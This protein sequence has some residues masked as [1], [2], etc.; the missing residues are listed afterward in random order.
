MEVRQLWNT[1]IVIALNEIPNMPEGFQL[2]AVEITAVNYDSVRMDGIA[3]T[4]TV[5]PKKNV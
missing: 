4:G 2:R 1:R 5:E 3:L